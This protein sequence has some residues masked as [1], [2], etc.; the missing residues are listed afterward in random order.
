MYSQQVLEPVIIHETTMTRCIF[1]ADTNDKKLL[2][3]ETVSGTII[4]QR[5]RAGD[6]WEDISEQKLSELKA[7]EGVKLHF[8]SEHIKKFYD[9]LTKLYALSQKGVQLGRN[10]YF[11]AERDRIIEVPENRQG[12][13]RE[14]LKRDF[15]TEV[16][17]QIVSDKPDLATRLSYSRIHE[18]RQNALK[19]FEFNIQRNEDEKYWQNFFNSNS[20]IFGYGLKYVFLDILQR[21]ASYGGRN[22]TGKGD[23]V[24]DFLCKTEANVRFTVL[25]E[26]KRPDT[27]LFSM[28][29]G[30]PKYY[31]NGVCQLSPEFTGAVSQLQVNC[32]AWERDS[33][34]QENYEQLMPDKI[35]TENPKGI[36]I[37]GNTAQFD[38]NNDARRTFE[39]FRTHIHGIDL[40]TFD[41]LLERAR[42]IVANTDEHEQIQQEEI[43]EDDFPF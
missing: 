43:P 24:G 31:R 27:S 39:E 33:R 23:E 10:E 26:I 25:V 34:T 4:H 17:N 12:F 1:R 41:E 22:F 19:E 8:K 18:E 16:W 13:V 21:E 9:G 6:I 36:L 20:W 15:G 2:E 35:Y 37:V 7:G 42:F 30:S 14:L 32:S 29:K 28:E 38:R 11:V 3:G 40:I 5:K